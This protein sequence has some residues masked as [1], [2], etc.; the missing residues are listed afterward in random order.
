MPFANEIEDIFS[1]TKLYS[2]FLHHFWGRRFLAHWEAIYVL[3]AICTFSHLIEH[4]RV[5]IWF[6]NMVAVRI[7][8]P[9]RGRDPI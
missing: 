6:D 2:V 4:K 7:L 5:T 8:N 3:V 9:G 1:F